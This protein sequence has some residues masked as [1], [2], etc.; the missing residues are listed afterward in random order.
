MVNPDLVHK[1]TPTCARS[2]RYTG[3]VTTLVSRH[4]HAREE[5]QELIVV[6]IHAPEPVIQAP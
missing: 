2:V 5:C 4:A 1:V 6:R 3:R